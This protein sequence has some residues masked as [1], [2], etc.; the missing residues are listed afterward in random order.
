MRIDVLYFECCSN[1][2]PTVQRMKDVL[3]RLGI[4]AEEN[5]LEVTQGDDFAA[6]KFVGSPSC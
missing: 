6:L 3:V 1:H 5:E 2:K 4:M